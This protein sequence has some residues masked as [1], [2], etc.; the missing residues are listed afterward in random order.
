VSRLGR[1]TAAH[2]QLIGVEE[3][4][5]SDLSRGQFLTR[6]LEAGVAL[7][8]GG[9]LLGTAATAIAGTEPETTS[10]PPEEDLA[11]VRLAAS[12]EL[13]AVAFYTRA[14]ASKT[15][16]REDRA[17]LTAAL[18]NERAHYE[19]L[20]R[21]LGEGAP[22]ADDFTFAFPADAFKSAS[23]IARLGVKLETAFLG[24]YAG[25]VGALQTPELR[26]TAAEIAASEATHLSTLNAIAGDQPVGP[27]F[28]QA[29]TVEEASAALDPFLGE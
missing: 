23:S 7:V 26:V 16:A 21:M 10:G 14:I 6:G 4:F 24:A 19:A 29:L 15:V 9:A 18:G 11:V 25:A 1:P 2:R 8:A 12:A 13:L 28:P 5:M 3:E 20:A 27:A 22:V 17:H